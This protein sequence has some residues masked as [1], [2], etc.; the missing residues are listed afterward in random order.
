VL[1]D[2][3]LNEEEGV[4]SAKC[5]RSRVQ[6]V[7]VANS[8]DHRLHERFIRRNR[9]KVAIS[10]KWKRK[11]HINVLELRAVKTALS[12]FLTTKKS[13]RSRGRRLLL[14]TDSQVVHG[15]LKKG[16]TSSHSLLVRAR[17]VAALLLCSGIRLSIRWVSTHLNPADGPSRGSF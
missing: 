2:L 5:K 4:V 3:S 8:D 16:R 11:E 7:V 6:D 15:V 13:I 10:A 9:W 12:W 17:A 14:F 1:N